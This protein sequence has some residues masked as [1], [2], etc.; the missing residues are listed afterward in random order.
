MTFERRKKTKLIYLHWNGSIAWSVYVLLRKEKLMINRINHGKD[1]IPALTPYKKSEYAMEIM[2][3]L[4]FPSKQEKNSTSCW[5]FARN[6]NRHGEI[7][8]TRCTRQ[9]IEMIEKDRFP[10]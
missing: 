5:L 9:G 2:G 3:V 1:F 10:E 8:F 6:I 7:S 4:L